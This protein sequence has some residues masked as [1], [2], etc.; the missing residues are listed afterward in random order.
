[1][2]SLHPRPHRAR[3]VRLLATVVGWAL[4]PGAAL[5]AATASAETVV[6]Y[7]HPVL[8]HYFMTPLANEILALDNGQITGWGRTGR[9][10]DAFASQTETGAGAASPVCRFYI[11]PVHG[12]SHFFSASPAECADVRAKTLTDP[13]FSG[14]TE[15]TPAEFYIALPDTATGACAAGTTPV[16]RLWNQ[17]A[18]SNHR[19]TADGA[20]RDAMIARGYAPEGYGALGVAMCTT[21]S[22]IG[23]SRVRVTDASPFPVECDNS[24]AVGTLYPGAEVEPY[25]AVD[26]RDA[27]HLIGVCQ[28]DRWSDG[29]A[30]GLRTAYSFDGGLTWGVSQAAFTRCTGGNAGNG[31]DFQRAS[32]PW[33]TIGPDGIAYQIAIAFT[34]NTFAVGSSTAVLASRSLDGGRTWSPPASLIRDGNSLFDDKESI[35]A[36]PRLSGFAYAAW[37]RL[38]QNGHGP[39]YFT[40]TTDGGASWE[41]ARAIH[42]P[43]DGNQTLN[44]QVV[45]PSGGDTAGTLY[46][47]FTEF[48]RTMANTVVPRLAFVKSIDQGVTWSGFN[49][50]T[51][52]QGIGTH[53]AQNTSR[54]LRDGANI[55]SVAAGPGG[56]LVAVWQEARFSGGARDGVAL[57]RSVDGG[58]TWSTPVQ[59][60][61]VPAVQ[62]F[63]PA[64][65]IRSDGTMA[66]QYYDMRNDTA[67]A[68]TLIVDVWL[69]TST[70]G[71]S[72]TQRHVAGPFDFNRVPVAEGGLFVGD[73]QGL[74]S[75]SGEFI[76][77]LTQANPLPASRTDV[78][79]SVFRSAAG[80][81]DKDRAI[82]R[83]IEGGSAMSSAVE[84]SVHEAARRTLA[85][86]LV[87]GAASS[88]PPSPQPPLPQ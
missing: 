59:I 70:D 45:I 88:Q 52:L 15:E 9:V 67:D 42:D 71:V 33:V 7:Y 11:P 14:Y 81:T 58:S 56:S 65:T 35:T 21:R 16:Y 82:Y 5:V 26:P 8:D 80:A 85:R 60:N 18:D 32:D 13:N 77:F 23:D 57:S 22:S 49:V 69:A 78:F 19:Y 64:V 4:W 37:D 48:V 84:Q 34:G 76:G 41:P 38:E 62:A 74:A 30:R 43:G 66:V 36:D 2:P 39:S 31:A 68:S 27:S 61:A 6:E 3:R 29:G 46:N 55:A 12:D 75:A 50:I 83:A 87:G 25:V 72:W 73:Y 54:K 44:N 86:R 63:L 10:F 51:N 47:F 24:Q 17:R 28:Q 1:M 53:D 20:T 40:R 79:A